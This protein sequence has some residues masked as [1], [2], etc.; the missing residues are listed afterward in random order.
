MRPVR[1]A[2][3]LVELLVVIA[4]IAVLIGLLLP[5]VQK[6]REAANR[7]R[8]QNHLK[9]L[10]VAA[11][12][13]ESEYGSLPPGYLGPKINICN[14]FSDPYNTSYLGVLALMLP[15]LEQ[16]ALYRQLILEDDPAG[17]N[18]W[19]SVTANLRASQYAVRLFL[20]PSNDEN[21]VPTGGVNIM[22]HRYNRN[23]A[24]MPPA[25]DPQ[26]F[27]TGT[28]NGYLG[29]Y[30]YAAADNSYPSPPPARFGRTHYFGV[31][32]TWGAG[33]HTNTAAPYPGMALSA[34]AGAFYDRS[35][36]RVGSD[37]SD[38]ASNTLM[39]GESVGGV[40]DGK[41][42]FIFPWIG[43]SVIPTRFGL[44]AAGKDS[45]P[46]PSYGGF[47]QFSSRHGGPVQFA[48]CDGSVRALAPGGSNNVPEVSPPPADWFTLQQLA[49]TRDGE[50][51]G[52]TLLLP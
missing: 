35:K 43:P 41:L 40:K 17:R 12:A 51:V 4:I 36:V 3:T 10:A 52:T 39:F 24:A 46:D 45:L 5:A 6:V 48:F 30:T 11:H 14:G 49:G 1:R 38:G 32:G 34:Y 18:R 47:T 9:Q 27:A 2:F 28:G 44:P 8:C 16:E 50:T 13:Y 25:R 42:A 19:F 23:T 33:D 37:V 21:A 7:S 31:N 15:Y 22:H 26:D 20:C 29:P